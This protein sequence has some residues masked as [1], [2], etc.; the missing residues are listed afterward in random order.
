VRAATQRK[1]RGKERNSI[2]FYFNVIEIK[3][4]WRN[5][6][7]THRQRERERREWVRVGESIRG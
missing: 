7:G 3:M 6:N 2:Q 1:E 4:I 5:T